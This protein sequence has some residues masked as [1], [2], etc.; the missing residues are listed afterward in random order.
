MISVVQNVAIDC[1]DA[2]GLAR[3]WSQVTGCPMHPED[4]PGDEETQVLLPQGPLLH[5]NQVPEH[6]TIKNRLHLCLRPENSREMERKRT[7][8]AAGGEG[9]RTRWARV[10]ATDGHGGTM[11]ARLVRCALLLL[12]A[13][14]LVSCGGEQPTA[15]PEPASPQAGVSATAEP[16][17]P[18]DI[19]RM[20]AAF[21]GWDGSHATSGENVRRP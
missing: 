3:F 16:D 18:Q 2:Y 17:A 21:S 4:R 13:T 10:A 5:F 15:G 11:R 19:S 1:A 7:H 6:E 8:E 20:V 12:T 9:S 14:A